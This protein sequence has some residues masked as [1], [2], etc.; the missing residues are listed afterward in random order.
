MILYNFTQT[1]RRYAFKAWFKSMA[2]KGSKKN[3]IKMA[4]T[5]I[6]T[7][8]LTLLV[9][10]GVCWYMYE[11]ILNKEDEEVNY[12]EIE[13]LVKQDDYA[14]S[15]ADN[16]ILLL[17]LDTEKR[18][19]AS[20]F[21]AVHFNAVKEKL[22]L[23]PVQSNTLVELN[24][25]TDT[26]YNFYRNGGSTK[27]VEAAEECTGVDFDHYIK[28]NTSS[29]D[30]IVDIFGG[31]DFNVPY[32]L[33]YSNPA[34]GEETIIKEGRTYIDSSLMR[35][36]LTYPNYKSGEE[37][38][39]KCLALIVTDMLNASIDEVFATHLDDY[40]SLVIN[41]DIETDITAYDYEEV[42]EAMK[43]MAENSYSPATF[44]LSTGVTNEDGTYTLDSSFVENIPEW[45]LLDKGDDI[46]FD[47]LPQAQP[48]S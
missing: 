6:V 45:F 2:K 19:S 31:V 44:V 43:Y 26:I 24:G 47:E 42:S 28:F 37:Y 7:I 40:F 21:L 3:S 4:V 5:Y 46:V 14:P 25:E 9:A 36:L 1:G 23:M 17:I 32:N 41:S 30:T 34:T 48:V 22:V 8:L 11:T 13:Q 39:A 38:R 12:V 29:F 16:R 18:E 20:A 15:Q 10:G 27:A 33:I 35:N